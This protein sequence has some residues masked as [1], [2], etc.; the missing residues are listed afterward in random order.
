MTRRPARSQAER[1]FARP[2]VAEWFGHRVFPLVADHAEALRDQRAQCCPFLS[3]V[4]EEEVTCVKSENSRGVC[5]ISAVSNG[6]RQD[7]LVCPNRAL[8]DDL[9]DAM[10]RRLFGLETNEALRVIPVTSLRDEAVRDGMIADALN[11]SKPLQFLT[12]QKGFGGEISLPRSPASPE[13]SFD[14]T[15]VEVVPSPEDASS[16]TLGRYGVVEVQTTDTHG[17]YRHAVDA[18]RGGLDLHANDFASQVAAHPDWPGRRVEG[19]NISNVFKRTFYQVMFKFQIARRASSSGCILALPR[20]VWDSWQPFL[21]AP[22][23]VDMGD[24][25][26]RLRAPG[27]AMPDMSQLAPNWIYVFDIDEEPPADGSTTPISIQFVIATDAAT[28]S[29]LALDVAPANAIGESHHE[30]SV[31]HALNRR[32]GVHIADLLR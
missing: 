29:R 26:H 27:E 31:V 25:T 1:E 10:V 15:V 21:G 13:L 8:D 2:H 5:T 16:V 19:P 23:V 20:P 12:F 3:R 9:M 32:V 4:A 11:P 30:D 28:L 18:L 22:D 7:W 24:G 17:S 14:I 6:P